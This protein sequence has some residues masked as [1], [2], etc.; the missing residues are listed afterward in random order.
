VYKR[1]GDTKGR[2]YPAEVFNHTHFKA[3]ISLLSKPHRNAAFLAALN[4][5]LCAA[6]AKHL[7]RPCWISVDLVLSGPG[8]HT[9]LLV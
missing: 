4:A 6:A 8:Y 5:D 7:P 3:T 9:E 2:A 1:Q